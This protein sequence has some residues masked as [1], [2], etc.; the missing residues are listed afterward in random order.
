MSQFFTVLPYISWSSNSKWPCKGNGLHH[1]EMCGVLGRAH[2]IRYGQKLN[3]YII[4]GIDIH[5]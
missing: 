3:L 5:F 1:A 4:M 2:V